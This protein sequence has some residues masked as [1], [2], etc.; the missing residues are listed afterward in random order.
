MKASLFLALMLLAGLTGR[1]R[2]DEMKFVTEPFPPF[3]YEEAGHA[4]GPL[5]EIVAAACAALHK[6]CPQTVQPWRRA[7][8]GTQAGTF[9]GIYPLRSAPQRHEDF[10]TTQPIVRTAYAFVAYA[11]TDWTY[12]GVE[13]LRDKLILVYGPSGTSLFAGDLI[14]DASGAQLSIAISNDTVLQTIAVARDRP[15][16]IGLINRDVAASLIERQGPAG[17]RFAGDAQ[18]VTYAIGLSRNAVST[19]DAVAF[20][21]ALS[22]LKTSGALRDILARHGLRAAD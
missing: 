3:A 15:N 4:A 8:E 7:L 18:A 2:A 13:S 6:S 20:D 5:A 12:T 9:Q 19:E 16:L 22:A 17:L 21:A 14:K 10:Y 1:S 11:G